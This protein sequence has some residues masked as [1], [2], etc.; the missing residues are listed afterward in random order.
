[1]SSQDVYYNPQ[2][3]GYITDRSFALGLEGTVGDGW[4]WDI[5]NVIGGND[6]HYHGYKTFNA[7]LD[8]IPGELKTNFNDGGFSFLQNTANL[9]IS[10]RFADVAK[11]MTLSFGGEYRFEHY[12][13]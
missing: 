12:H 9:D 4:D 6:F 8:N 10:K 7:T 3:K 2:E 13:L 5:S 11:G 1:I